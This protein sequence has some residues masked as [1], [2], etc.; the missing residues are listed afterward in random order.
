MFSSATKWRGRGGGVGVNGVGRVGERARKRWRRDRNSGARRQRKVGRGRGGA[1]TRMER[2][3]SRRARTKGLRWVPRH[4][5]ESV[6][7]QM[8]THRHSRRLPLRTAREYRTLTEWLPS[9][10]MLLK[11]RNSVFSCVLVKPSLSN[12]A[13]D[14]APCPSRCSRTIYSMSF[15]FL[16]GFRLLTWAPIGDGGGCQLAKT[17]G[18]LGGGE[19]WESA[20]VEV[21]GALRPRKL[22]PQPHQRQNPRAFKQHRP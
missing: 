19:S 7:A 13:E 1:G 17:T 2:V 18:E 10:S 21:G 22:P 12:R 6:R 8:H 14:E 4:L 16:N 11:T 20:G 9:P 5:R 15:L 3:A